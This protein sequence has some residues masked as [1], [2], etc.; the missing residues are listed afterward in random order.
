MLALIRAH[1]GNIRQYVNHGEIGNAMREIDRLES[2]LAQQDS[3]A[4]EPLFTASMYGSAAAAQK[5]RADWYA[6]RFT[7]A[8]LTSAPKNDDTLKS[9]GDFKIGP[10]E[11]PAWAWRE[12]INSPE[13]FAIV[14]A[15]ARALAARGEGA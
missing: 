2:A 4:E 12:A 9:Q 8:N 5:A 1:L 3:G 6:G 15:R 11:P 10:P 7:A 14:E 13:Y